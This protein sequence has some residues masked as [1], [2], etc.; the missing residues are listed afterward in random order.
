MDQ[1]LKEKV[2]EQI[3]TVHDP[4]IALNIYE[5][6]L[7]YDISFD[8]DKCNVIM[9]LTSAWCPVAQDMPVWVKD[10]VMKVD[11]IKDCDVQVVFEPLW[12]HDNISEDGKLELGLV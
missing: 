12:G 6:G 1:D 8:K 4:E 10:A 5:L 3:R 7:I 9:T 11:G 2:I